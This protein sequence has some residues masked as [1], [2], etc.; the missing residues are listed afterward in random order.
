MITKNGSKFPGVWKNSAKLNLL[1]VLQHTTSESLISTQY[2]VIE[3]DQN[4]GVRAKLKHLQ[5]I[6]FCYITHWCC[7]FRAALKHLLFANP[8]L[9]W[10]PCC[11]ASRAGSRPLNKKR[12]STKKTKVHRGLVWLDLTGLTRMTWVVNTE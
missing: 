5:D 8:A 6:W 4:T 3:V 9:A 1:Y 7:T 11:A 2:V 10:S 12:A